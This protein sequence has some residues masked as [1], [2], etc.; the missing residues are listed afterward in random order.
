MMRALKKE[1]REL[2]GRELLTAC[3]RIALDAKA[4]DV[5]ALDLRGLTFFTDY[6]L[7][8]SG[9]S[10]RHTQ[11]LAEALEDELHAKRAAGRSSE[12]VDEGL[13]V[14]LDLGDVVAHIFYHEQRAFYDLE[15]LWHDAPRVDLAALTETETTRE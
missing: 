12:G 8:M 10:T 13:W 9:R 15:G 6:F 4:E 7:I 14:A 11:A 5:V 3:A 1:Y 2:E